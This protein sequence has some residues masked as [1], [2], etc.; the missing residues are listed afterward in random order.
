[1]YLLLVDFSEYG[2]EY[3]HVHTYDRA[4][5]PKNKMIS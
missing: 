3:M 5:R 2:T 4:G 1:M